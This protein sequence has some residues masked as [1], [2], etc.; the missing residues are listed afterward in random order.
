MSEEKTS[1]L[2]EEAYTTSDDSQVSKRPLRETWHIFPSFF[3]AYLVFVHLL[4]LSLVVCSLRSLAENTEQPDVA[5][6]GE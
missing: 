1:L 2:L 6:L 4:C 3:T 5:I